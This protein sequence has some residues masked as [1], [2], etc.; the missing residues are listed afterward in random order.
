[1]LIRY[2]FQYTILTFFSSLTHFC[3]YVSR[4]CVQEKDE[5]CGTHRT[6]EG[7][8]GPFPRGLGQWEV[9]QGSLVGG[10]RRACLFPQSLLLVSAV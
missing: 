8:S 3:Y 4:P 2:K 10:I 5:Y 6:V 9:P 1:M 7:E